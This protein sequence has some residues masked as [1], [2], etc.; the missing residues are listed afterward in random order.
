M[1]IRVAPSHVFVR[2]HILLQ[3]PRHGPDP[4][5]SANA[6]RAPRP[7][8]VRAPTVGRGRSRHAPSPLR[9]LFVAARRRAVVH[10]FRSFRSAQ[11][12][13]S[14]FHLFP[15]FVSFPKLIIS[16]SLFFL[17]CQV[18]TRCQVPCQRCQVP[19][20]VPLFWSRPNTHPMSATSP[21][22]PGTV[23][24]RA[25]AAPTVPPCT[26]LGSRDPS[27]IPLYSLSINSMLYDYSPD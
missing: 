3:L 21:R 23:V 13:V 17:R 26:P 16:Y 6:S 2:L 8:P 24:L 4:E 15:P 25:P 19:L 9:L 20:E 14:N 10:H 11:T 27:N 18:P 5:P 22:H 12:I 7:T 1:F